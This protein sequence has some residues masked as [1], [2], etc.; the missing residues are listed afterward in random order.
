MAFLYVGTDPST[1]SEVP[2]PTSYTY[3]LQDVSASDSGRTND[4]DCTMH[5]NRVTQKRKLSPKWDNLG[6]ATISLIMQAFQPEYVYVRYLDALTNSYETRQFYTGDKSAPLRSVTIGG[7][8][9]S[10]LS[11]NLIEV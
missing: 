10:S 6:G 5:K 4:P 11:F 8:T 3:G 7:A 2:A 1:L 9:Y